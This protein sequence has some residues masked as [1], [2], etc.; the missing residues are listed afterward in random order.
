[1]SK[2]EDNNESYEVV[3]TKVSKYV[4]RRMNQL[5]KKKGLS[6]YVMLQ[7]VYETI[8]R[9]MDDRHNLT[10][11]MERAMAIFEHLNGWAKAFNLADPTVEPEIVCATYYLG[12][13]N[14]IGV[15]AVHVERPILKEL[16][17][18][19]MQ[20]INVQEILEQTICLLMPERY[21]RLRMLAIDNDCTSILQL[22]D[23][24]IDE[25]SKD[26][27]MAD[28]RQGFEDAN[29]SEYGRKPADAPYKRK[30]YKTVNDNRLTD[31]QQGSLFNDDVDGDELLNGI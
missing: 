5:L 6:E 9:Y 25:H 3:A 4:R 28:I 24:L 23:L 26:I 29:R 8:V 30:H 18:E 21:K 13:P 17:E 12:D 1:M 27:D 31:Q 7:M 14:K 22:I 2:Q 16:S 19:W 10:P 11:E 20:T 15:H